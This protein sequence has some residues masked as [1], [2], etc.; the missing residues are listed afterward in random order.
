ML[1]NE[2][3]FISIKMLCLGSFVLIQ[4]KLNNSRV[5]SKK[6][7]QK[8]GMIILYPLQKCWLHCDIPF[9]VSYTNMLT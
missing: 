8:L 1:V 5:L 4:Y 2:Q 3:K 6:F 9:I 7:L